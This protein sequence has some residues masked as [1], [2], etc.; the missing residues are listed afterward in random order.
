MA[1]LKTSSS[2]TVPASTFSRLGYRFVGWNTVSNGTGTSYVVGATLTPTR[3][4]TLYAIWQAMPT[5]AQYANGMDVTLHAGEQVTI[6]GLPAG[7]SYE[8]TEVPVPSGWTLAR[9]RDTQG[10]ILPHE[11]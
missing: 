10:I 8:V 2:I 11:L 3:D 5:S 9:Q 6:E 4:M 1:P 7:A